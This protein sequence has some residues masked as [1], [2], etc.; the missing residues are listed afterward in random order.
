MLNYIQETYMSHTAYI[1]TVEIRDENAIEAAVR[2]LAQEGVNISIE[3][4]SVPRAYYSNQEGMNSPADITLR[5]GDGRYDV[6]LYKDP[7]TGTYQLRADFWA[8]DI[9]KSLG[10]NS[11]EKGAEVGKFLQRYAVCAAELQ[12]MNQ[13]FSTTRSLKSDGTMQLLVN[14]A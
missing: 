7:K 8:G 11:K 4:N 3:R 1:D 14:V 9:A 10:A 12:A 13:G 2:E 5:L 6:G